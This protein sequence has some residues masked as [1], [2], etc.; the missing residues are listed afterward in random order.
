VSAC[1]NISSLLQIDIE[2]CFAEVHRSNMTKVCIAEQHAIDSVNW[3]IENEPRYKTPSYR[4][5]TNTK[6]WV[7]YDKDTSKILKSKFFELPN[8]KTIIGIN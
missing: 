6:Y 1:Y 5:S 7:I 2:K 8:L 3:Y 4:K